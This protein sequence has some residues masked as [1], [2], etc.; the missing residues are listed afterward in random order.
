MRAAHPVARGGSAKA[1][2]PL[3][4]PS[5]DLACFTPSYTHPQGSKKVP[6]PV[7][8]G[9]GREL[10]TLTAIYP[11]PMPDGGLAIELRLTLDTVFV[12]LEALQAFA[13]DSAGRALIRSASAPFFTRDE[14]CFYN[15]GKEACLE[16]RKASVPPVASSGP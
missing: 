12:D 10:G 9:Y 8:I 4:D 16:F 15:P 5:R 3:P 2:C 13:A 1:I 6:D 14:K 11:L 7:T